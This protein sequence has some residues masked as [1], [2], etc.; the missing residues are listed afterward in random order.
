MT[1]VG[2]T[3][4]VAAHVMHLIKTNCVEQ[5]AATLDGTT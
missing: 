4:P 2:T 5:T 3:A 1:L